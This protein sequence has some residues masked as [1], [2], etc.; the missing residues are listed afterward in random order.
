[1]LRQSGRE[2]AVGQCFQRGGFGYLKN[3][4]KGFN[5]AAKGI[6][7]LVLTDLDQSPCPPAL[8]AEWL[9][10][11]RQA[12]LLFRVAV[13]QVES[14]VLADQEAFSKFLGIRKALVP[15]RPDEIVH[16][17]EVLI[18]LA[19]NSRKRELR[20]DIVPPDGSTRK[21]GPVYNGR[22]SWFVQEHW[23][24]VRASRNSPSLMRTRKAIQEFQPSY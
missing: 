12:N 6:P 3:R 18:A 5:Q 9:P 7:F 21:Q 11:D 23:S 22:L 15:A 2:F 8:I 13:H 10:V 17:K 20:R 16:A 14:W 4:I 1:V 19:R 24:L